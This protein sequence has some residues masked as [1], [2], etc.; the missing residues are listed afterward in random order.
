MRRMLRIN[1]ARGFPGCLGSIDCQHWVWKNCPIAWAGQFKG[2]GKKPTV[3]LEAI[4]DGELW[5][6]HYFFG[7]AGSLNDINV[8]DHST[9]MG[10]MLAGNFPPNVRFEVNGKEYIMPYFLADGIYPNWRIFV[11]T[12]TDGDTQA[13]RLFAA[14]Q[15]AVRKDVERAF[16]VLVARF[17]ILT[18]GC[19]LWYKSDI[20][21]V[22]K[23]CVIIHKMV[24]EARRDNYE[25]GMAALG[26]FD[27]THAMFQCSP[28]FEW[29][30]KESLE[31]V[32]GT[33]LTDAIWTSH[34]LEREARLT[35]T[36][37]HFAL[38]RDLISHMA[39][40]HSL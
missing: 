33:P 36:V 10:S 23:A 14:G 35:S 29:K 20:Q 17:H 27:D 5:I 2:K 31:R 12:V 6:W 39:K 15:E 18:C 8:L 21:N 16:G 1:A 30:S 4:S 32:S 28:Q 26:L 3:V 40:E 9:T 24:V 19:R 34:V 11:K 7:S 22:M 25:S 37:D 38:K 13:E